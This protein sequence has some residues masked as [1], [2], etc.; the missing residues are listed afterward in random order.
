M[1][2]IFF[3]FS[4]FYVYYEQYLTIVQDSIHN[5]SLSTAAIFIVT[6]V[7]LGFDLWSSVVIV[8]TIGMILLSMF[9]LMFLWDITLNAVSLVNLVMVSTYMESFYQQK[10]IFWWGRT[11]LGNWVFFL[12]KILLL[13]QG[14]PGLFY[15]FLPKI[16]LRILSGWACTSLG[17]KN[18]GIF[19]FSSP[20]SYFTTSHDW[21]LGRGS[22]MSPQT[23]GMQGTTPKTNLER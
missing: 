4:V 16:Y 12:G 3:H 15:P 17:Y 10:P 11:E 2:W 7:L 14:K 23:K 21:P 20:L 1:S 13:F 22:T 19:V 9:G 5:L 6:F 8:I 18:V